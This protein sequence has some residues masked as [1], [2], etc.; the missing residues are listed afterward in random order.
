MATVLEQQQSWLNSSNSHRLAATGRK[1]PRPE[2]R[3]FIA[4]SPAPEPWFWFRWQLGKPQAPS[5]R[6]VALSSE[7]L[8]GNPRS[9]RVPAGLGCGTGGAIALPAASGRLRTG[10]YLGGSTRRHSMMAAC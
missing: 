10:P 9:E 3:P 8:S 1:G 7:W 2:T 5:E 4:G 6:A